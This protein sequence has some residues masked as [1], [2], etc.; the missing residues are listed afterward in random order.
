MA[1]HIEFLAALGA[2]SGRF[3]I[4]HSTSSCNIVQ[5][6]IPITGR[7]ISHV[8]WFSTQVVRFDIST[9]AAL[10]GFIPFQRFF[11]SKVPLLTF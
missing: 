1:N 5:D 11:C 2:I 10:P 7:F 3:F 9:R 8:K 4:E 6:V